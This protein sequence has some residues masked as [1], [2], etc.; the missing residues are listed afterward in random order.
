MSDVTLC[1]YDECSLWPLC[2]RSLVNNPEPTK[3]SKFLPTIMLDDK[4]RCVSFLPLNDVAQQ[5]YDKATF[6]VTGTKVRHVS[7]FKSK[8]P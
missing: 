5:I 3:D 7:D 8:R 1:K 2:S 4:F 6:A